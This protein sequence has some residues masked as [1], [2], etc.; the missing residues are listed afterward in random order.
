MNRRKFIQVIGVGGTAFMFSG[1]L[2]ACRGDG[3]AEAFAAWDPSGATA[4]LTDVRLKILSY[5]ILAP[6]PHNTQAWKVRLVNNDQMLLFID[7]ERLLPNT[8][9]LHRQIYI[10]QGTFLEL[11][12][13]S[14][15]AFGQRCTID[16]FP[17]GIDDVEQTGR[18]P[19]AR[20]ALRAEKT[21][22]DELFHEIPK[23]VTNRLP[24]SDRP[25]EQAALDAITSVCD[26]V[27]LR[28]I[29]DPD[30]VRQTA[31][32]VT[33]GMRV[34]TFLDRTHRETVDMLRFSDDEI[35][36]HRDGFGYANIGV[37]GISRFFAETFVGRSKAMGEAFR[38]KT[39]DSTRTMAQSARVYG[40]MVTEQ[41]DRMS[42]IETGRAYARIH[43]TATKL[44]LALHPMSQILQ[45]YDE[46]SGVRERFAD[47]TGIR[48]KTVQML[49]RLG[50]A[51]DV[52]HSPRRGV[53]DF[54]V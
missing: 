46:L 30:A 19:V 32:L 50:H 7:P 38:N 53:M 4:S 2:G 15:R 8:D 23:R 27:E 21:E 54:V 51:D 6:N 47:L 34:E 5:A 41:N 1:T 13:I 12:H 20:M 28:F 40:I 52:P 31:D 10:G 18:L 9:P 11:A 17:D 42:Q 45:E 35:L 37:T 22:A 48:G 43:L 44:G 25:V 3:A 36:T 26:P 29:I 24:F 14:A 16:L 39:V 33:E 49:F